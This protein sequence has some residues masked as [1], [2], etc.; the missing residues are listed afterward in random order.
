MH[1]SNTISLIQTTT[2]GLK[3]KDPATTTRLR[4]THSEAHHLF[5]TRSNESESV[6]RTKKPKDSL[7]RRRVTSANQPSEGR[8]NAYNSVNAIEKFSTILPNYSEPHTIKKEQLPKT[9]WSC[10][11]YRWAARC[12]NTPCK[13]KGYYHD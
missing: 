11:Q 5:G 3:N 1:K 2:N 4:T 6:H 8:G 13:G 10:V 12:G 9:E 7:E